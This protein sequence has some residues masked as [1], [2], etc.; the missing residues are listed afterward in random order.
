MLVPT[1]AAI[2]AVGATPS[3]ESAEQIDK[4]IGRAGRIELGVADNDAT[5]FGASLRRLL[6]AWCALDAADSSAG[7]ASF[8]YCQAMSL[9]GATV[10][11]GRNHDVDAAFD[12]F[13]ELMMTLRP[14]F[15]GRSL[16][17]CRVEVRALLL[18]ATSRWPTELADRRAL[19]SIELVAN[20]WFLT[21]FAGI[22]SP[23]A[24]LTV[25]QQIV[26]DGA[27]ANGESQRDDSS[28]SPC[29]DMLLRVGIVLLEHVMPDFREA[30]VVD[31]AEAEQLDDEGAP[32]EPSIGC[33]G[34]QVLSLALSPKRHLQPCP[35]P[36]MPP[37]HSP[38]S[39]FERFPRPHRAPGAPSAGSRPTDLSS[40]CFTPPDRR[41]AGPTACSGGME[42]RSGWRRR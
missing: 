23:A 12:F 21:C 26:S 22:L 6:R 31:A 17:G 11:V 25:M 20:Q 40:L 8:C 14:E 29:T 34:Y 9:V 13:R 35:L 5:E 4:D 18:L 1:L 19:A 30:I 36:L 37:P 7:S 10:L 28:L 39:S 15:Y 27:G 42:R 32:D 41:R 2:E 3:A 33:H 38:V 24:A 16:R